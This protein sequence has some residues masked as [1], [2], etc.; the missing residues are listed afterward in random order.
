VRGK[1]NQPGSLG[2]QRAQ[3]LAASQQRNTLILR[4]ASLILRPFCAGSSI[5]VRFRPCESHS[6][7]AL[8]RSKASANLPGVDMIEGD[9]CDEG[10]LTC[11]LVVKGAESPRLMHTRR[12]SRPCGAL[13]SVAY[14]NRLIAERFKPFKTARRGSLLI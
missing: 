1:L 8:V 7:V 3:M 12:P 14:K 5:I 6:I 9:A 13:I 2:A 11:S 10:T 4:A